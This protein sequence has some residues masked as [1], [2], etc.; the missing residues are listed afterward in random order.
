MDDLAGAINDDGGVEI[1]AR[2][3][4]TGLPQGIDLIDVVIKE[5]VG[6]PIRDVAGSVDRG[7]S[8]IAGALR[9][10]ALAIKTLARVIQDSQ[11]PR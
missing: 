8:D 6:D 10:V 2:V 5:W 7:A 1:N 9:D 3:K 11:V 4:L